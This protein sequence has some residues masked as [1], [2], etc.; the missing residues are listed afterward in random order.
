MDT[1][2]QC[3]GEVIHKPDF[4]KIFQEIAEKKNLP[5][6]EQDRIAEQKEWGSLEVIKT[7]EELFVKRNKENLKFNQQ[8]KAYDKSSIRKLLDY[9]K[10]N[11]LNNS[12]M[13]RMF[14]LNRITLGKWQRCF[15]NKQY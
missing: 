14:K 9:Q 5:K 11:Q 2:I 1:K 12:E 4:G 8:H 10:R 6:A 7:N 13:T 15:A 3:K